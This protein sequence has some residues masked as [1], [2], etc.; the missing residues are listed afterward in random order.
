MSYTCSQS[1]HAWNRWKGKIMITHDLWHL[2]NGP[3]SL[4]KHAR[5]KDCCH[6]LTT[7]TL[8]WLYSSTVARAP[9][10]F[11]IIPKQ[12]IVFMVHHLTWSLHFAV[13]THGSTCV[14]LLWKWSPGCC[15]ASSLNIVPNICVLFTL[16]KTICTCQLC[17][18]VKHNHIS[19]NL[20]MK[21]TPHHTYFR[22][23]YKLTMLYF[24]FF[25]MSMLLSAI[26]D[27]LFPKFYKFQIGFSLLC[28]ID[29]VCWHIK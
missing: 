5:W 6:H 14:C 15:L 26:R 16:L 22:I 13:W 1:C 4:N 3:C 17:M 29:Q 9:C 18:I 25:T 8:T 23:I 24:I 27:Y 19:F 2:F 12:F 20:W 10:A 7:C 21:K 28:L 11:K